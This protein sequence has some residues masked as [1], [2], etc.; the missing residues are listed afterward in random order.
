MHGQQNMKF[1]IM[2]CSWIRCLIFQQK[3]FLLFAKI[4]T[5][6]MKTNSLPFIWDMIQAYTTPR[7]FFLATFSSAKIEEGMTT[8]SSKLE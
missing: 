6:S 2:L 4:K 5:K 7:R 8:S 3:Y 1:E